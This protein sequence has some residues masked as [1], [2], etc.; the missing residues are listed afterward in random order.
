MAKNGFKVIDSDM[1]IIE[2]VD[3]WQRYIDPGFRGVAP[4]GT[5][6]SASDLN[7]IHPDGRLWGRDPLRAM[8]TGRGPGQNSQQVEERYRPHADRGYSNEVQL[9]AMDIE[10]IDVA[11]IYPSRGLHALGEPDMDPTLAAAVARAYND[12]LF[13]FCQ[14][15][16]QRL[17]GA[18]M[19][20][21]FN[22]DDAVAESRRAVK[23][24][25][26]RSVFLRPNMVHNRPWHDPY[27]EPLW[28]ALEDI[29]VPLGFHEAIFT[30]LPQV[31]WQFG[32]NFMLR[33]TFCHPVEQMLCVASFAGAGIFE[34][35][36]NLKVAFLEGNC[37]WLPFFLWRL[38]EHWEQQ[39]DVWA[40]ELKMAPSEYFMRQGYASVEADEEPVKYAIDW[41]PNKNLVF[42]TD[43]PHGDSKYPHAV[44][45]FLRLGD[46]DKEQK[47]GV[48]DEDKRRI[49]WDNCAELYGIKE[50]VAS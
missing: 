48:S 46:S 4:I 12:W 34:H 28:D 22:I 31:G 43:Y 14:A 49:L 3:L 25:G 39:G 50:P 26:F 16:P 18:G 6:N 40:P 37:S 17:L 47:L 42:S 44:D 19:I 20:S 27:Y 30:G 41:M 32:Q 33:H 13:D 24:L 45:R 1:H 8:A 36:P 11:V 5:A 23:E 35:H 10:G 29:G 21:V 38:D 7:L 9:E 2:P 15:D